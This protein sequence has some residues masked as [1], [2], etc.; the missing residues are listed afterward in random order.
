MEQR[1]TPDDLERYL[2]TDRGVVSPVTFRR[3]YQEKFRVQKTESEG[4]K[5]RTKCYALCCRKQNIFRPRLTD[6]G[7]L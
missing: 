6:R 1:T 5:Q 3:S 7:G 2:D 4:Q